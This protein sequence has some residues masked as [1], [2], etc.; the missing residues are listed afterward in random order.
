MV[1]IRAY[2]KLYRNVRRT[3]FRTGYRP[4][5]DFIEE[6]KTSGRIDLID[7]KQFYPGDEG[8]VKIVFLNRDYLGDDFDIG[9]TFLFGEGSDPLG[10]GV[11]KEI[12]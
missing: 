3:P 2:I 12:L 10:E 11:V 9:K 5:F 1:K 8:E 7:R 6:M 4:L